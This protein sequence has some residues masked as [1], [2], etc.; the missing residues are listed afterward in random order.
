MRYWNLIRNLSNWWLHFAVKFRLTEADPLIFK[1]RNGITIETPR[2]LLHEFKEIFL[3]NAYFSGFATSLPRNPTIIDI[4][5]NAGF[6]TLFAASSFPRASIYSFEPVP[7]NFQQLL[8]NR[9]RNSQA[10]ISCFPVAVCGSDGEI[11]LNFE[12]EDNFTT[13]AT[14]LNSLESGGKGLTV[15]CVS[16]ATIFQNNSLDTCD[17]LKLDCEGAEFEILYSCPPETIAKVQRLAMEVH[18]GKEE[19]NNMQALAAWLGNHGFAVRHR[20][21]MLWAWRPGQL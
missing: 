15:P 17:L 9:E 11:F 12:L 20:K 5:A 21:Q 14:I 2:R 8:R 10:D 13:A 16:L 6:F 7:E 4:G 1:A 19:G 3:E 18:A